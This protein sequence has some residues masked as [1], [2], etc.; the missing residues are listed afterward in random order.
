[1]TGC[2]CRF[3]RGRF[4]QLVVEIVRA[5][6]RYRQGKGPVTREEIERLSQLI[7]KV[8]FKIPGRFLERRSVLRQV[9]RTRPEVPQTR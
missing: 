9:A 3:D 2:C 7:L 8:K 5:G 6:V 1:M 4:C